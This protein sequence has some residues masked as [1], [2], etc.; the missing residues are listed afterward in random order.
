M[1]WQ[2]KS[3]LRKIP[4]L[5]KIFSWSYY[6]ISRK[7]GGNA[8]LPFSLNFFPPSL[9]REGTASFLGWRKRRRGSKFNFA[10]GASWVGCAGMDFSSDGGER[11]KERKKG[12]EMAVLL[13]P[14]LPLL[15]NILDLYRCPISH[16]FLQGT[17]PNIILG[18]LKIDMI[19]LRKF[20]LLK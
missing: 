15:W 13:L 4:K 16:T 10:W 7:G 17:P 3:Y 9:S 18:L 8:F 2:K 1:T 20:V 19:Y 11:K 5:F 14:S 12:D 6:G